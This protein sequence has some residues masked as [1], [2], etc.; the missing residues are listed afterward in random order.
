MG[1]LSKTQAEREEQLSEIQLSLNTTALYESP[2]RLIKTLASIEA[3]FGPK[4]M[5]FVGF[6]LTKRHEQHFRDTVERVRA[7]LEESAEGTRLKGEVTLV[8][9][10]WQQ[11]EEYLHILKDQQF[12]PNKDA[13]VRIN[14]LSVAKKLDESIDMSEGEFRDLLKAMFK[15]VPSYHLATVVRLVK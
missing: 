12:N 2:N 14:L 6:E 5:V 13:Q 3:V 1:Y 4:H 15:D 10:P 8:I 11:D 9:A 7:S